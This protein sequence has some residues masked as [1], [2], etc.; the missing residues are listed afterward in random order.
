MTFCSS[1]NCWKT[2]GR[3]T[4]TQLITAEIVRTGSSKTKCRFLEL[5]PSVL[6]PLS[7]PLSH[8]PA[9]PCR[10]RSAASSLKKNRRLLYHRPPLLLPLCRLSSTPLCPLGFFF[11]GR[12]SNTWPL[13]CIILHV[14]IYTQANKTRPDKEAHFLNR[15]IVAKLCQV[16]PPQ[17]SCLCLFSATIITAWV[18]PLQTHLHCNPIKRQL[19]ELKNHLCLLEIQVWLRH[20]SDSV[21][22]SGHT[23]PVDRPLHRRIIR[24]DK[25]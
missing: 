22:L 19:R 12:V 2:R 23:F 21:A 24:D 7:A 16:R 25:L 14:H 5:D 13:P 18:L 8:F 1:H 6:Q 3:S 20:C 15:P 10:L 17:H 4:P 9:F 11:Y